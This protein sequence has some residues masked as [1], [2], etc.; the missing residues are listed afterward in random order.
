MWVIIFPRIASGRR[1]DS[2]DAIQVH[3]F[4]CT[5]RLG[6]SSLSVQRKLITIPDQ[7]KAGSTVISCFTFYQKSFMFY[8]APHFESK[9][10]I[11]IFIPINCQL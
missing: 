10:Y 8:F 3:L 1:L 6:L 4:L 2:P 7:N 9:K 5:S 11:Y